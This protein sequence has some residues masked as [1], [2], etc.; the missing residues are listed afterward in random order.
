MKL[1]DKILGDNKRVDVKLS[2]NLDDK[3]D[4]IGAINS[5]ISD[6]QHSRLHDELSEEKKQEMQDH[7]DRLQSLRSQL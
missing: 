7:I 6:I 3:N 1:S 2:L 4:L 5:K